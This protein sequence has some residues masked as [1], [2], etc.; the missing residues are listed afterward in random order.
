MLLTSVKRFS[1]V[2][3][4]QFGLK[5]DAKVTLTNTSKTPPSIYTQKVPS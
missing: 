3:E 2:I 1:D 5:Q 4:I